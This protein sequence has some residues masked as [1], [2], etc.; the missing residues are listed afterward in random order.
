L[1]SLFTQGHCGG[2]W[3][4]GATETLSD[5]F[6]IAT[7]G[8]TNVSLSPQ[9]LISCGHVRTPPKYL[10]GCDGGV[11]EYAWKVWL[12]RDAQHHAT[13]AMQCHPTPHRTT[14]HL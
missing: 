8:T 13:N 3:A 7:N 14:P 6:C 11:P 12:R 2:C 10:L 9:D 5:R 4:F 1:I